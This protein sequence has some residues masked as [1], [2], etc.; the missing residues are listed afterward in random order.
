MTAFAVKQPGFRFELYRELLH[1]PLLLPVLAAVLTVLQELLL[2]DMHS[3][4]HWLLLLF[5][6]QLLLLLLVQLPIT[7]YALAVVIADAMHPVAGI[8]V[9][10]GRLDSELQLR[11]PI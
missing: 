7:A 10:E 3:Q 9:D 2:L 6:L 8:A 11:V 1:A 4:L 5:S